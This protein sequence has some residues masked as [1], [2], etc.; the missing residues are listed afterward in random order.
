M[1][2]IRG[3]DVITEVMERKQEEVLTHSHIDPNNH[4][5]DNPKVDPKIKIESVES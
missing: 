3:R 4:Q 1:G 2:Y 5:Q